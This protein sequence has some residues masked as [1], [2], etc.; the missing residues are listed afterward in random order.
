MYLF[1]ASSYPRHYENI[2]QILKCFGT[3]LFNAQLSLLLKVCEKRANPHVELS[4]FWENWLN[5]SQAILYTLNAISISLAWEIVWKA[6]EF[7]MCATSW[8]SDLEFCFEG[9]GFINVCVH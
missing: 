5:K 9:V 6:F 4:K 1:T 3:D 2:M 7:H 8:K